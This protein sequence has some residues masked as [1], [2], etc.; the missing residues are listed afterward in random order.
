MRNKLIV[1]SAL[2]MMISIIPWGFCMGGSAYGLPFPVV[3]PSHIGDSTVIFIVLS[4]VAKVHGVLLSP[5][6]I[7]CNYL[8]SLF[9]CILGGRVQS[10]L[11]RN[12]TI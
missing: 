5:L 10:R 4:P 1:A 6:S 3:L 11:T 12:M 9:L 2:C 8:L 7:I